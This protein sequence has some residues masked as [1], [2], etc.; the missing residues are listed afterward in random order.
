[1]ST[2]VAPRGNTQPAAPQTPLSQRVVDM[3]SKSGLFENAL[4]EAYK[5]HAERFKA[6]ARIYIGRKQELQKC[7]P[8]SLC[9]CVLSAA[10]FGLALDGRMAH[11]VAFNCKVKDDRGKPVLVN[12]SEQ[13]ESIATFMPSYF[14][15]ID[16][17]RRHRSIV[18]AIAELVCENDTFEYY[19]ENARYHFR[20]QR[21]M[22]NR[23]K[24]IGAFAQ[25]LFGDDRYR[26]VY[27]DDAEITH[28]RNKSKAA[29]DGPWVTDTDEMRKKTVLKRALK[30]YI[31]DPESLDLI[32][33]DDRSSGY[34][35]DGKPVIEASK[36]AS[37]DAHAAAS[38]PA[39]TNSPSVPL[40]LPGEAET[41][42]VMDEA[43]TFT[44]QPQEAAT[45]VVDAAEYFGRLQR[46]ASVNEVN[47]LIMEAKDA[48]ISNDDF[49]TLSED[50]KAKIEAIRAGRGGKDKQQSFPQ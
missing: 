25:L 44:E 26:I 29:K 36:P 32:D 40:D 28:V 13:W 20:W 12:G 10:E 23:G 47:G 9:Q 21:A 18:D 35:D 14:G 41:A 34:I 22:S 31:T 19:M 5:P 39:L 15:I 4:P 16:V 42:L 30:T 50:A 24:V 17:C 8:S 43:P 3:V 2:A 7:T 37:L 6:R 45:H 11:A 38:R 1:M 48:A 27:M 49:N 33:L 46:C